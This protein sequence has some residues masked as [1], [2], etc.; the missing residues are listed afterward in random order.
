MQ[1]CATINLANVYNVLKQL[2]NYFQDVLV[3]QG[4]SRQLKKIK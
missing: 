2:F 4:Y 1:T 3:Q